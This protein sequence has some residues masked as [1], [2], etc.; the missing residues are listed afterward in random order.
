MKE[1]QPEPPVCKHI[2]LRFPARTLRLSPADSWGLCN[3]Q[4][5][6]AYVKEVESVSRDLE[7]LGCYFLNHCLCVP[8][9]LLD[10]PF[11]H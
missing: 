4:I 3:H 5:K 10:F 8:L 9:V 11:T 2:A 6:D 7:N 1:G